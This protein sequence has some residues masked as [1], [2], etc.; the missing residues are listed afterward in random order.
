V[1]LGGLPQIRNA[2]SSLF[3]GL[4]FARVPILTFGSQ[5]ASVPLAG[6]P[7]VHDKLQTCTTVYKSGTLV[8]L[9]PLAFFC[10]TP[11]ASLDHGVGF[12]R[13]ISSSFYST[14]RVQKTIF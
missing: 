1:F 14:Q 13:D 4:A 6:R 8:E 12:S 10:Q 2:K 11:D 3:A 7:R 9:A 5:M